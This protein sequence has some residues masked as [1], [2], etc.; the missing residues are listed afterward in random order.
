M[1]NRKFIAI[2]CAL[3]LAATGLVACD[4]TGA[5]SPAS[6]PAMSP[7]M[8]IS[9]TPS[10]AMA[11]SSSEAMIPSDAMAPSGMD[12]QETTMMTEEKSGQ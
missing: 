1:T 9:N 5:M 6:A 4:K 2:A 12:S 8:S 3:G 7:A 10:D 11:P